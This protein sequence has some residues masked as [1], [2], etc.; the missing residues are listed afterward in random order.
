MEART[1]PEALSLIMEQRGCSQAR[2]GR[3][4]GKSQTWVS[5]VINGDRGHDFKKVING[6]ARVGWEV[7]IRPKREEPDAVKRREFHQ[8]VITIGAA[9]AV[10]A[11]RSAIFIP[12]PTAGPFKDPFFIRNLAGRLADSQRESGGVAVLATASRHF[13]Q[14]RSLLA[15]NDP[16]LQQAS[17][18]LARQI[19][20]TLW[21]AGR[22]DA[23]ENAGRMSLELARCANDFEGQAWA[24]SLLCKNDVERRR[25]SGALK[26][27]QAGL[28]L[29]EV[30][31]GVRTQLT[32]RLGRSLSLVRG[33]ERNAR[34]HIDRALGFEGADSFD[35]AEIWSDAGNSLLDL[36]RYADAYDSF[37][38][39]VEHWGQWSAIQANCLGGQVKAAL[40]AH[41]AVP[42]GHWLPMAADRMVALAH[43]VPLVSS[44]RVDRKVTDILAATAQW[45][46]V[47]EMRQARDLLQDVSPRSA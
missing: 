24:F 6:L 47:P 2:L 25:N 31:P 21:D 5:A 22:F 11:A 13:G 20:W 12:S 8:R 34:E 23:A 44:A 32:M 15:N 3:D 29:R 14:I 42:R 7:V 40:R 38:Q 9:S 43:T 39:A 37:G 26:Y 4:M 27:A 19:G 28:Q 33:Q 30:A 17:A 16:Q 35:V 46:T 18:Y 1:L 36:G 41:E 45:N 10:E